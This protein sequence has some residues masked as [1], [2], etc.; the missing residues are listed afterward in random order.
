MYRQRA[1][2]QWEGGGHTVTHTRDAPH[3]FSLLDAV[4]LSARPGERRPP[5]PPIQSSS[6]SI[7]TCDAAESNSAMNGYTDDSRKGDT[8]ANGR[9]GGGRGGGRGRGRPWR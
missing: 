4:L 9:R 7:R 3:T 2:H 1:V 6:P 8:C 5:I